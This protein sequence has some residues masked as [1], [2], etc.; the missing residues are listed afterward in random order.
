MAGLIL[1]AQAVH[2]FISS[3]SLDASPGRE[4]AVGVQFG[5]A[6]AVAGWSWFRA[7]RHARASGSWA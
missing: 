5:V 6:L 4:V 7:R 3:A 2:W 1:A